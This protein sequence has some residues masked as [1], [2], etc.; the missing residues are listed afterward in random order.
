MGRMMGPCH[1]LCYTIQCL[2]N[3]TAHIATEHPLHH[4]KRPIALMATCQEQLCVLFV[5]LL[6]FYWLAYTLYLFD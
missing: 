3:N 5:G 4:P 2:T 1:L 6:V